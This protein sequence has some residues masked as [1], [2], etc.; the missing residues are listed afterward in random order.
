MMLIS[1]MAILDWVVKNMNVALPP[2]NLSLA[3]YT[4]RVV[5]VTAEMNMIIFRKMLT[6]FCFPVSIFTICSFQK[7]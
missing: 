6:I 2:M 1:A 3:A 5:P 4:L 7:L